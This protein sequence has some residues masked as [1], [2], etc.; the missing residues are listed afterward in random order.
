[1]V[2]ILVGWSGGKDSSATLLL[3]NKL[4][5]KVDRAIF[6]EVMFDNER[7][8]SA[9]QPEHIAWMYDYAIPKVKSMGVDVLVLRSDKDFVSWY[10][11]IVQKSKVEERIG[12]MRGFPLQGK[13]GVSRDLKLDLSISTGVS[14]RTQFGF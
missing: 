6:T 8:I 13:C 12:K 4:G 1:M 14:I 7:G 2:E 11:Y 3:A 10:K 9:E 5:I